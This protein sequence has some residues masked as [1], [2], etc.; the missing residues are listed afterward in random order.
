MRRELILLLAC[1]MSGVV[2]AGCWDQQ[3]LKDTRVVDLVGLDL[4]PEGKLQVT[5]S[6]IDVR[7]SQS[8]MKDLDEFHT[9]TGITSRHLRDILDREIS[10]VYSSSK[11]RVILIGEALARRGIYP[12]LDVYYRDPRSA[13][14]AMIAI[15]EGSAHDIITTTKTGTKLIGEHFNKLIQSTEHRTV[16]PAVNLQL[17][18]PIMLDPGDDFAVPYI[19]KGK[20]KPTVYGVALFKGDRMTGKLKSEDSILYLMMDDK[21]A[22]IASLTL[23]V[24]EGESHDPNKYI[25]VDFQKLKRKLTVNVQD[26]RTIKVNLDLNIKATA[27]EYAKDHLKDKRNLNRLDKKVSDELT[28]RAKAITAKMLQANHDGFGIGRR[29]MAYY[30]DIWKRLQWNQDYPKVEF[31]PNVKVEITNHGIMY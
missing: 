30:P 17:I 5:S 6:V 25:A 23:Q 1:F 24:Q 31:I 28:S 2:L 12:Y 14:N 20:T 9:A 29:L 18:C 27:I 22:K 8:Q 13:L 11:L 16:V 21:L 7:G 4:G 3:L 15:V 10:G 26:N 19:S